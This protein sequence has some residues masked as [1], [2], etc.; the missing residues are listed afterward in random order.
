VLQCCVPTGYQTPY[1]Q[2]LLYLPFSAIFC[3]S[4]LHRTQPSVVPPPGRVTRSVYISW[5]CWPPFQMPRPC[6]PISWALLHVP[7]DHIFWAPMYTLSPV[8][9]CS[10][11][12]S[13]A[14][15]S[16]AS[17]I[18][19]LCVTP[20]FIIYY[21][22]L[23]HQQ[24]SF[25]SERINKRS[26]RTG[27]EYHQIDQ[28]NRKESL[29]RKDTFPQEDVWTSTWRYH[30]T[31]IYD[32]QGNQNNK[33]YGGH[34]LRPQNIWGWDITCT[35]DLVTKMDTSFVLG[36]QVFSRVNDGM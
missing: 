18:I 20:H 29:L 34:Y 21:N 35:F 2:R 6:W 25:G 11:C 30:I 31:A 33:T 19:T 3:I 10:S 12:L 24:H 8:P 22:T 15:T 1:Y 28:T 17:K 7:F 27:G 9:L 23:P 16:I 26:F 4:S 32:M 5:L 14:V 13:Y 36:P